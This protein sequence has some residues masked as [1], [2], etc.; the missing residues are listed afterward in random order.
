A[1]ESAER[2]AGSEEDEREEVQASRT[3]APSGPPRD[4]DHG[5]EREHVGGDY[6]LDVG[7][8]AVQLP[9]ERL[10]R[11]VDDRRVED[12][13]DRP[14]DHDRGDPPD[15]AL[16]AVVHYLKVRYR[17]FTRQA[18]DRAGGRPGSRRRRR[19]GRTRSRPR[20]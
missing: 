18:R 7:E 4:R 13:H 11:D 19:A 14:E 2:G 6:P 1:G 15:V 10:E 17:S 16:D 9:A 8:G 12:R 5:R 3:K 20:G